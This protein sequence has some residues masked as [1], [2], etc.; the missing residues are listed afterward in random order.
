VENSFKKTLLIVDEFDAG[1][2]LLDKNEL[3][4]SLRLTQSTRTSTVGALHAFVGVGTYGMIGLVG[5]PVESQVWF[6]N[7]VQVSSL[8]R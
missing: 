6:V 3:L 1:L 4:A 5:S 8:F 2:G 7:S